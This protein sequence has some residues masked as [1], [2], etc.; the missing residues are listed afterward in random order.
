MTI[1]DDLR[2]RAEAFNERYPNDQCEAA[3]ILRALL[4]EQQRQ[5]EGWRPIETAPRDGTMILVHGGI[6]HW[7]ERNNHWEGP[8]GW[9]SLTGFD[10]PG[11][12]IQWDVRHWM[13][14]P[15]PPLPVESREPVA[16]ET[17]PRPLYTPWWAVCVCGAK[18]PVGES[19]TVCDGLGGQA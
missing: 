13:P 6:A 10:W 1:S 3:L 17:N 11:R 15:A 14:F 7:R 2:A 12:P 8:S 5:Q 4:A 9:Y 19:C 18:Y 16:T